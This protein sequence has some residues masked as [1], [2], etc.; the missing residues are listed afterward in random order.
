MDRRATLFALLG[1]KAKS[2]EALPTLAS[3]PP[4][5]GLDPY[6]GPWEFEQA[7]HLLRRAMFGPTKEQILQAVDLGLDG[8][9]AKLLADSPAPPLPVNLSYEEDEFV[10][11][12][13]SWVYAPCPNFPIYNYRRKSLLSWTLEQMYNEGFS[14]R[15][16]MTLFW[17][18]HFAVEM[19]V[20]ANATYMYFYYNLLQENAFGNFR[21]LAKKITVEPAMLRYLNGNQSTKNS[22]NENYARELLEL[23][24]IGKGPLIGPGDYSN[25]TEGDIA[26]IAR[27]LTGWRDRGY[28][29]SDATVQVE[30]YYDS[31]RH[32]KDPKQLSYHFNNTVISNAEDEEYKLLI[33]IIFQQTE[34]A[35]FIARKIYRWFIYYEIDETIEANVIAPM[36][37]LILDNDYELKPALEALFKSE[38]FFEAYSRGSLIKNPIDFAF[39]MIK[40]LQIGM[41]E[42]AVER[43]SAFYFMYTL[44]RLQQM[45]ILYPPS[46]AGWPAYYQAPAYHRLWTNSVTLPLR[47]SFVDIVLSA[48]TDQFSALDFIAN[49]ENPLDINA[50]IDELVAIFL[51]REITSSQH[52]YLKNIVLQGLPDFEWNDQYGDY[53]TDP[54]N[55]DLANALEGQLRNLLRA[56]FNLPEFQLA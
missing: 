40:P 14:A 52:D 19:L 7:A 46:V 18:N 39:S 54:G 8:T 10:P 53:L 45:E 43:A 44:L 29:T 16:K 13:Q 23:F 47:S 48:Q 50:L 33:D 32:D 28:R 26:A 21:E 34:P 15:E 36:A 51:P 20:V 2:S 41:P 42:D 3:P 56:L 37:Q 5:L 4:S 6:T 27:V 49:F 30:S 22:P 12:G 38:H 55:Q 1:R 17:H 25:Y 11:V 31:S 9:V 24:T 35:Y